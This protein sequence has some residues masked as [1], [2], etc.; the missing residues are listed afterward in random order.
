MVHRTP[1]ADLGGAIR[2][3]SSTW[4]TCTHPPG[5]TF[6]LLLL[7]LPAPQEGLATTCIS[8]TL[9]Q[10][11]SCLCRAIAPHLGLCER[12]LFSSSLECFFT[13]RDSPGQASRILGGE[14]DVLTAPRRK[15]DLATR[16]HSRGESRPAAPSACRGSCRWSK[17]FRFTVLWTEL[18]KGEL[19]VFRTRSLI[20]YRKCTA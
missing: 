2:S 1:R 19:K 15:S 11:C 12:L 20:S 8:H 5:W 6:N 13:A 17:P 7:S 10:S 4:G 3:N 16:Q 14:L 9:A 18:P